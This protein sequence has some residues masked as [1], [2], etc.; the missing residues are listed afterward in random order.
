MEFYGLFRDGELFERFVELVTLLLG[1]HTS[2]TGLTELL[3]ISTEAGL[4]V[5]AAD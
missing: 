2:N 4:E 3:Y 5:S 1:S